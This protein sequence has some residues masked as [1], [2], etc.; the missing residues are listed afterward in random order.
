M[1][2]ISISR[3]VGSS[4]HEIAQLVAE[5][6]G[7]QLFGQEMMAKIGFEAGLTEKGE[8]VDLT[9]EKHHTHSTL[10]RAF[11]FAP[12]DTMAIG[13]YEASGEGEQDRS[14]VV[15][16]KIM[17]IAYGQGNVVIEG[18]GG[19]GVLRGKPDVLQVRIV[20]PVEQR[21]SALIKRDNCIEVDARDK[22]KEADDSQADYILRYFA[23]DINDPMLYDFMINTSKVTVEVA[24]ATIIDAVNRLLAPG[25]AH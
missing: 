11:T 19:Q 4:G 15:V 8:V 9:A 10:E 20:A 21:V 12:T 17:N 16:T 24:A 13:A 22:V 14:A 23:A 3:Q 6:L 18:R 2:V 1:A 25:A 5:K 7:Y